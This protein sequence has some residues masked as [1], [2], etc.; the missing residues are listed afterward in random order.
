MKIYNLTKSNS[1][2]DCYYE[3]VIAAFSDKEQAE[4]IV[5]LANF[6]GD[7]GVREIEL[8]PFLDIPSGKVFFEVALQES[9]VRKMSPFEGW[10]LELPIKIKPEK[11]TVGSPR[12]GFRRLLTYF[13]LWAKNEEEA[14]LLAQAWQ[15]RLMASGEWQKA[16][17]SFNQELLSLGLPE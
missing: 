11:W 8:N 12:Y 7:Y 14:L 9:Q 15:A 17:E 4:R 3:T 5:D 13:D 1:E 6:S 10:E 2:C 16:I